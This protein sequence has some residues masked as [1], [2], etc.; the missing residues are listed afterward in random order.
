MAG[1]THLDEEAFRSIREAHPEV[2]TREPEPAA[3]AL[4]PMGWSTDHGHFQRLRTPGPAPHAA[5]ISSWNGMPATSGTSP[6]RPLSAPPGHPRGHDE[7]SAA[8]HGPL[9]LFGCSRGI[10][11]GRGAAGRA[12][13]TDAQVALSQS[14]SPR[15][16]AA[17]GRA[18]CTP[19][20]ALCGCPFGLV[21]AERRAAIYR[22][23]VDPIARS[24][25]WGTARAPMSPRVGEFDAAPRQ[26][27]SRRGERARPSRART[28]GTKLLRRRR[29]AM[30]RVAT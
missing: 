5:I 28:L 14:P 16:P 11:D 10:L 29:V 21:G 6:T 3:D 26:R 8:W 13:D 27:V 15:C 1:G 7:T 25:P 17:P 23:Y 9:H 4:P 20:R 2:P 30:S 22:V 24:P 19:P 18:S 12:S